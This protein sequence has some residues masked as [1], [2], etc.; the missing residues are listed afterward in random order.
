MQGSS[1]GIAAAD[2]AFSLGHVAQAAPEGEGLPGPLAEHEVGLPA[3]RQFL[4]QSL[5]LKAL[6]D[7]RGPSL[8]K[9]NLA[10]RWG[11]CELNAA[12]RGV[13]TCDARLEEQEILFIDDYLREWRARRRCEAEPPCSHSARLRACVIHAK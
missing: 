6:Q 11:A 5:P 1:M 7:E 12:L 4:A 2:R 9:V 3:D 10:R 8:R 13:R